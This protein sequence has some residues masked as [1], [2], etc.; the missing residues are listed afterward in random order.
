[1]QPLVRGNIRLAATVM[2]LKDADEGL[3]VYMAKR[4]GK[5]VFPD[6]YVFPGGKVDEADWASDICYGL[7]DEEASSNMNLDSGALRYWV[8]AAR[9][10]FEECG[11]LLVRSNG[12]LINTLSAKDKKQHQFSREKLLSDEWSFHSIC[13]T[14]NWSIDC[15]SLA[16]FSHWITPELAPKRFDTRFF[17][18]AM[19]EGQ[20]AIAHEKE[21][22]NAQWV[23]PAVA[24]EN[25]HASKWK[26]IDPTIR[27]LETLTQFTDVAGALRGVRAGNHLMPWTEALGEQGMQQFNSK[28]ISFKE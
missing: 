13:E 16:Y 5:G 15:A 17:I 26:M 4:P 19:P 12:R 6:I 24:L 2:L 18:A 20:T 7:S 1:M 10:C 28:P 25:F 3:T 9:E 22:M 8:A 23:S 14:E 21:I 27:S 11:V